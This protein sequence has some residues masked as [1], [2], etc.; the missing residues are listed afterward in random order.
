[1]KPNTLINRALSAITVCA[2]LQGCH[3][4]DDERIPPLP[5]YIAFGTVGVWDTY[6]VAG[7]TAHKQF[8]LTD[9]LREPDNFPY[10]ALS[11]TGFGGVLLVSDILGDPQAYDLACPVEVRQNVRV[12]VDETKNV[13]RC[14]ECESEYDIYSNYGSPLSGPAA[15][16]GYGLQ[17]Y[18]V[19]HGS[20]T[21]YMVITR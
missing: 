17:R 20:S 9:K 6:G 14:R 3:K 4:I 11:Q 10:T 15:D 19:S 7:A 12:Y 13:A 5:V 2:V 1:M 16:Y 18:H 21:E 8:I